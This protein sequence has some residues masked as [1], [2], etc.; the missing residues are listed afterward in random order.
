[1]ENCSYKQNSICHVCNKKFSNVGNLNKH[2]K[3]CKLRT[4]KC[5]FCEKFFSEIN[6]LKKHIILCVQEVTK[7]DQYI[8]DTSNTVTTNNDTTNKLLNFG[9]EDLSGITVEKLS[10]CYLDPKNAISNLTRIMHFNK[11]YPQNA[12]IM[13]E[14]ANSKYIK[15]YMGEMWRYG[16]LKQSLQKIADKKFQYLEMNYDLCH[17][18]LSNIDRQNWNKY[19]DDY[20]D[21]L[22]EIIEPVQDKI[23]LAIMIGSNNIKKY[24]I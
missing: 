22:P 23:F 8:N 12:N 11:N 1:M 9:K 17:D 20:T 18:K 3:K 5:S 16:D 6:E 24:R 2:M 21:K 14:S 4:H 13:I 10:Q 19:Y 7:F 15:V